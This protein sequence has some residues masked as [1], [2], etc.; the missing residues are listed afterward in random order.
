MINSSLANQMLV[1][2]PTL[3]DPRFVHAVVYLCEHHVQGS[4]GLIINRPMDFPF[5]FVL[6]QLEITPNQDDINHRPL[7]YGG[8]VQ[9]DRGFVLHR[10]FGSWKSSLALKE[11]VTV[12]TSNDIIKAI[13]YNEGP[14]DAL[15]TLGYAHWAENQLEQELMNNDW[16]VCPAS[17]ELLYD[18]PFEKRWLEAGESIGVDMNRLTSGFGNA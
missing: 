2:M 7:L 11:D 8:P 14:R 4:V 1:A 6:E 12:T 18:V 9:P 17:P 10:P 15:V 3:D 5:G 13:A 16:L